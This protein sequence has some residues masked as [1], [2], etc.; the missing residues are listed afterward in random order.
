MGLRYSNYNLRRGMHKVKTKTAIALSAVTLAVSGGAGLS[1]LNLGS[2][3]AATDSTVTVTAADLTNTPDYSHWFMYN[4]STDAIDN[5]LGSFVNGPSTPLHGTGSV[6]FT[7]GASPNDRKNIATYQFADVALADITDLSFTAY[8]SSGIAGPNESPFLNFNVDF[9]GTDTWQKR[10]VYVPSANMQNVPQDTW[11]TFDTIAGGEGMW[12]WSGYESNGNMWPDGSTDRYRS[13]SDILA[14]FPNAS[15]RTTDSW[16]G[17]RVGEPGPT[18][19]TGAVDAITFGTAA[20]VTTYDF[21]VTAPAT[22]PMS[23]AECKDGG[24][25]NFVGEVKFKNQGQCVAYVN[26]HDGVGRDDNHALKR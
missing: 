5:T 25:M 22:V 3:H 7:L 19:Y 24:W 11:N 26:H 13:W 2:A 15:T 6:Q 23:K 20:G 1:L 17:V 4:D 21:E 9:N 18:G 12:T 16:F 10:L 8:S 14:S